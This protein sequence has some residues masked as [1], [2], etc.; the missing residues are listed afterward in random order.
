M[1]LQDSFV[2]DP[3][4]LVQNGQTVSARVQSWDPLKNRL[5]LT[6]RA[7]SA[8][9]GGVGGADGGGEARRNPRQGKVATAGEPSVMA[10][11]T[12]HSN[13]LSFSTASP[14]Q[15]ICLVCMHWHMVPGHTLVMHS[16]C[17]VKQYINIDSG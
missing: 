17:K 15:T 5:S 8:S 16:A 14:S 1:L 2:S 6:M 4:N 13:V 11:P 9:G 10:I 7:D 12:V 3:N